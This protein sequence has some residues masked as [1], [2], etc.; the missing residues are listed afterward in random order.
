MFRLD[1]GVTCKPN[2]KKNF[3]D[4]LGELEEFKIEFRKTRSM[5]SG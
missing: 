5:V 3:T 2:Y 4:N 1:E